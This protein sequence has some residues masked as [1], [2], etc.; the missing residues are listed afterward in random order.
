MEGE[1]CNLPEV[2][3]MKKKYG[4]YVYLDEAYLDE[5][6]SDQRVCRPLA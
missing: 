2:V 5:A 6:H 4:A 3:A 1:F